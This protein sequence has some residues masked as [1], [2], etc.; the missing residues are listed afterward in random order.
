LILASSRCLPDLPFN[1]NDIIIRL[2]A[3]KV[4]LISSTAVLPTKFHQ[5]VD[6][7]SGAI[8]ASKASTMATGLTTGIRAKPGIAAYTAFATEFA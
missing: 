2:I 3:A 7:R 4:T 1:T 5:F 6:S 8:A